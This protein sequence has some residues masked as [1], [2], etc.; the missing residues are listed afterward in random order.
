MLSGGILR[1]GEGGGFLD[2]RSMRGKAVGEAKEQKDRWELSGGSVRPDFPEQENA[3]DLPWHI[4]A[5]RAYK[6]TTVTAA[7]SRTYA[8][9]EW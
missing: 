6:P 1:E 5:L 9:K 2:K 4:V 7:K 8:G 3:I